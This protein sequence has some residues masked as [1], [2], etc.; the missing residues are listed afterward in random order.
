M[1]FHVLACFSCMVP[2]PPVCESHGEGPWLQASPQPPEALISGFFKLVLVIS[3]LLSPIYLPALQLNSAVFTRNTS[4]PVLLL[5][6]TWT[7]ILIIV[8]CTGVERWSVFRV[9][10]PSRYNFL[11]WRPYWPNQIWQPPAASEHLGW[12]R[13][14]L[15]ASVDLHLFTHFRFWCDSNNAWTRAHLRHFRCELDWT[16]QTYECSWI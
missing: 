11:W 15:D 8:W 3:F 1:G 10:T 13:C 4:K 2:G 12:C 6:T 14:E 9:A 5:K 7:P 16:G